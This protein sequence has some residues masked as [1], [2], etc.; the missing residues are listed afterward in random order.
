MRKPAVEPEN[1][2]YREGAEDKSIAAGRV[3]ESA[4]R[5]LFT[6]KRPLRLRSVSSRPLR[7]LPAGRRTI[8]LKTD[9]EAGQ[10]HYSLFADARTHAALPLLSGLSVPRRSA[11]LLRGR[12][13]TWV[14]QTIILAAGIMAAH[15]LIAPASPSPPRVVRPA[16]EAQA[17]ATP[18]DPAA[19]HA[20]AQRYA[21]GEGV[22]Q[23]YGRAVYW[24]R[25][26]SEQGYAASQYYLGLLCQYGMGTAQNYGE[27][28]R[29]Y[30]LAA[31]QGH[32]GAQI[33]LGL[34]Y[35]NGNGVSADTREALKWVRLAAAQGDAQALYMLGL[36]YRDGRGVA[37][38]R[39]QAFKWLSLAATIASDAADRGNAARARDALS[40]R[41]SAAEK[42]EAERLVQEWHPLA[43]QRFALVK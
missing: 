22:P 36:L 43:Q 3:L 8:V 21:L 29:W 40:G 16:S 4:S 2:A 38:D 9:P 24:Y 26:A 15:A 7:R 6:S 30:R 39:V 33:N 28:A 32:S 25:R 18:T 5:H 1:F 10:R 27:A 31:L 35:L 11:L 12:N 41:L 37:A 42:R 19:Q 17:S 34:L 20:M 13:R 14:M 23:D